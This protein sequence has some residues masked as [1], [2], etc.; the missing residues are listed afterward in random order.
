MSSQTP[1]PQQTSPVVATDVAADLLGTA[2]RDTEVPVM[3]MAGALARISSALSQSGRGA[4][5]MGLCGHGCSDLIRDDIALCI[6]S[7]QFH[8]RLIQQLAAVRR[9]MGSEPMPGELSSAGFM[10]SEGSVELF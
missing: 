7:L 2:M 10:P 5:P 1:H 6:Q 3:D 4:A 9:L 8:D